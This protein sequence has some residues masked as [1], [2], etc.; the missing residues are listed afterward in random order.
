MAA[1]FNRTLWNSVSSLISTEAHVFANHDQSGLNFFT[2]NINLFRDPRWGRGQETPGEDPLLTSEY[3]IQYITGLQQGGVSDT[4]LHPHTMGNSSNTWLKSVACC[5]HYIAYDVENTGVDRSAFDAVVSPRDMT[6]SYMPPFYA[7]IEKAAAQSVMC[8][9]NS[10]NGIPG[11]A[12]QELLVEKLRSEW[13]FDGFITG[14]CGAVNQIYSTHHYTSTEVEGVAMALNATVDLDCGDSYP[15]NMHAALDAGLVSEEQLDAAVSR[16][17]TTLLK[18]GLF[19]DY[20]TQPYRQLDS[21][22]VNTQY[23]QQLALEAA[24]QSIVLLEA[25]VLPLDSHDKLRLAIT[26]P[27]ANSSEVMQ[28]NYFGKAPYLITPCEAAATRGL[29]ATCVPAIGTTQSMAQPE[30]SAA[31]RQ[32]CDSKPTHIVFIGG[33]DQSIESEGLDRKD[34]WLPA[35]QQQYA[36]A[37]R[38]ECGSDVPIVLVLYSGGGI[39]YSAKSNV[40]DGG[41]L[42]AG[43]PGQSGGDAIIRTIVGD[44]NPSGRLPITW[45]PGSYADETDM[46]DMSFRPTAKV[47]SGRTYRFYQSTSQLVA[48]FGR[49]GSYTTW[50]V[51]TAWQRQYDMPRPDTRITQFSLTQLQQAQGEL[52]SLTLSVT[53][54]G[55]RTGSR[56]ILL[57]STADRSQQ[58]DAPLRTLVN[59]TRV[60]LEPKQATTVTFDVQPEW[61]AAVNSE[62]VVDI[63]PGDY[64]L[65]VDVD[66]SHSDGRATH[67]VTVSHDGAVPAASAFEQLAVM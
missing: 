54:T 20:D 9:Y 57:Y 19:D 63:Q 8:S 64:K 22:Y 29:L 32:V 26:G 2:P 45:Y 55:T 35:V 60:T 38:D 24:E 39:D 41:V 48:G 4:L 67:Y 15:K 66:S 30:L 56:S 17:L 40:F 16:T 23:A 59:F 33:L 53:N 5:K 3:T 49:G 62:G 21:Q 10:I 36:Q 65:F 11:C 25:G 1:S 7:C 61:F 58:P 42:W 18:V 27:H 44:V 34:I 46:G 47:P 12:H 28:G 31:A 13:R 52:G 50:S 14:D 51:K 37:L 43:Y 6:E